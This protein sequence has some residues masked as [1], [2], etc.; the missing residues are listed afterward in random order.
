VFIELTKLALG[1]FGKLE[2]TLGVESSHLFYDHLNLHP[3]QDFL[4]DREALEEIAV[5][6]YPEPLIR[7]FFKS[8]DNLLGFINLYSTYVKNNG[9][10]KE[11]VLTHNRPDTKHL[12]AYGLESPS[13]RI[14]LEYADSLTDNQINPFT[15]TTKD[16]GAS[17]FFY[18]IENFQPNDGMM[19]V[20]LDNPNNEVFQ[21][22]TTFFNQI[23]TDAIGGEQNDEAIR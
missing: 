7:Q 12:Y 20:Y 4:L 2:Q 13:N 22:L 15:T 1:N 19:D 21:N 6:E 10:N 18:N 14:F 23:A 16:G 8:S 5:S 17:E 11:S 3:D 9:V